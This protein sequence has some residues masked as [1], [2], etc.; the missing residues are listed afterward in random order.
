MGQMGQM[1]QMRINRNRSGFTL[2]ELLV[3]IAIIGVMVGL[4]LPAVQAAR[5]AARRMSCG[6]NVKQLGLGLHNYHAAYNQLPQQG[7][8]THLRAGVLNVGSFFNSSILS[9]Q[10]SLSFL[11]GVTPFIE[12]QALWEQI[13]GPLIGTVANG[14]AGIFPA[15]GPTP[16]AMN[17]LVPNVAPYYRPWATEVAA[18]RCPSDPGLGLPALGRTNYAAGMGD[19]IQNMGWGSGDDFNNTNVTFAQI[20]RAAGRGAFVSHQKT[21]FRDFLDGTANTIMCGEIA[22]DLGDRSITTRASNASTA[23]ALYQSPIICN[24]PA[25]IDALRPRFWAPAF[26]AL[27]PE[28]RGSCWASAA[29]IN[30]CVNTILPPNRELCFASAAAEG[31]GGAPLGSFASG[32]ATVSSRHQGG[33]HVLMGDGAV[34]FITDSIEAGTSGPMVI[35]GGALPSQQPGAISPY[36]LWGSLG[37]RASKE[38]VGSDF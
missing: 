6:N 28:G 35:M 30:T 17:A 16:D 31:P 26:T 20:A 19:S 27:V 8:G 13:S 15:M 24:N 23:I 7:A 37:T 36:G 12:N 34:K 11:V 38:V 21:G 5:E 25:Q 2:V 18:L 32:V 14:S 9:N 10:S 29:T 4:L 3:V 22:T 33:G 1:G